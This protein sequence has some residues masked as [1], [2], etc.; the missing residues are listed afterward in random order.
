MLDKPKD[1]GIGLKVQGIGPGFRSQ[2]FGVRLCRLPQQGKPLGDII[3]DIETKYNKIV[4]V[5]RQNYM[6]GCYFRL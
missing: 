4:G 5:P 3:I 2:G 1:D 6:G